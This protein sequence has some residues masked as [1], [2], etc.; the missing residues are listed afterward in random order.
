MYLYSKIII[1]YYSWRQDV[2]QKA[3]VFLLAL[4]SAKSS[5]TMAKSQPSGR[6]TTSWPQKPIALYVPAV[7][8]A[9]EFSCVT[10]DGIFGYSSRFLADVC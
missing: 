3:L 8:A 5:Q 6:H 9:V 4:T 2:L 1:S 7:L 10:L